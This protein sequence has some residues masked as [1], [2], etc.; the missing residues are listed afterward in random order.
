MTDKQILVF[1]CTND[2]PIGAIQSLSVIEPLKTIG[3]KFGIT[4]MRLDKS[5]IAE[6]FTDT[7]HISSA[8]QKYPL[9]IVMSYGGVEVLR[10]ENAWLT[11]IYM[12][13]HAENWAIIE[14]V[15]LECE[16]VHSDPL[17]LL[18]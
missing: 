6:V 5:R 10:L 17:V 18:E 14:G 9:Q 1:S 7:Q 8:T 3:Q 15:E 16:H 13:F 11:S 4:R 2:Q 12:A